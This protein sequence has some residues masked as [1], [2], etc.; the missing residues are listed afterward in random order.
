MDNNV[1]QQ[2]L[3]ELNALHSRFDGFEE[4]LSNLERGQVAA[5]AD[6]SVVKSEVSTLK[7][8]LEVVEAK[9]E[10]VEDKLDEHSHLLDM[11]LKQTIVLTDE[12]DTIKARFSRMKAAMDEAV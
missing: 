11:I 10:G 7:A 9:L 1:L 2:I 8:K 3:A 5:Q 6:V 4:R 12:N